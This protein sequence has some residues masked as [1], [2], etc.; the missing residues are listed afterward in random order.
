VEDCE[1]EVEGCGDSLNG[2]DFL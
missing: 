1:V 2:C